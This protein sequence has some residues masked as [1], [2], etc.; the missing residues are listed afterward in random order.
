MNRYE[1]Y[2]HCQARGHGESD[3]HVTEG[4][5]TKHRCTFCGVSWWEETTIYEENVPKAP[6]EKELARND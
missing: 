1:E 4:S 5:V 2:Q 6:V 3:M